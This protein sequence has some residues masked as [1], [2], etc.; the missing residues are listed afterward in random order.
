MQTM[1]RCPASQYRDK[2]P[3]R[4]NYWTTPLYAEQCT[5]SRKIEYQQQV[6]K[7]KQRTT[8][9]HWHPMQ[10]MQRWQHVNT[11][12]KQ[13]QIAHLLMNYATSC[14]QC[15]GVQQVN[16]ET[17]FPNGAANEQRH[18]T[19]NNAP[20]A[21]KLN[22]NNKL[23]IQT[24]DYYWTLRNER[25]LGSIGR[26]KDGH[27]LWEAQHVKQPYFRWPFTLTG[28]QPTPCFYPLLII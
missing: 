13:I 2:L 3:K 8:T 6:T 4:C 12:Q 21:E 20:I 24:A 27:Y 25:Y 10:A 11:E 17:N 22:T 14:K 16:T 1:Q 5:N 15:N 18:S 28:V 23:Q 19:Q 9:E 7:S 26:G